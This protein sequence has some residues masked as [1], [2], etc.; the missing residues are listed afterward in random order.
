MISSELVYLIT[1]TQNRPDIRQES[2]YA[3]LEIDQRST[4]GQES[5][6]ACRFIRSGECSVPSGRRRRHLGQ[7]TS[8][9]S[10]F[11][12]YMDEEFP[13]VVGTHNLTELQSS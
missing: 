3:D 11:Q 2:L 1:T 5:Q 10:G 6:D 7:S 4:K 13:L 8:C 12:E 9:E